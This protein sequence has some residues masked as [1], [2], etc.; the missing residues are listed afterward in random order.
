MDFGMN[1]CIDTC[2]KGLENMF[3]CRIFV[4]NGCLV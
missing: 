3:L 1:F 2:F 4:W